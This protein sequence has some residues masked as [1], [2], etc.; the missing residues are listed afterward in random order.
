MPHRQR[1]GPQMLT[2]YSQLG[3]GSDIEWLDE[4]RFQTWSGLPDEPDFSGLG[5]FGKIV[6]NS[7]SWLLVEH[8]RSTASM[9]YF[10]DEVAIAGLIVSP[11]SLVHFVHN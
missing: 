9:H 4:S 11:E 6:T 2:L 7:Y 10:V 8:Q 5:M 1:S 3:I